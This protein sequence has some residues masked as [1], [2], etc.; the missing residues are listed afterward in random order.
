MQYE[1]INLL[2]QQARE[3]TTQKK[4]YILKSTWNEVTTKNILHE[5]DFSYKSPSWK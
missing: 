1:N 5:Q 3:T 2:V 4:K